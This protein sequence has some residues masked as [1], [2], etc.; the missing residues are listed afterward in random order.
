[1]VDGRSVRRRWF[2]GDGPDK[3][4]GAEGERTAFRSDSAVRQAPRGS[5]VEG[6]K[7]EKVPVAELPGWFVAEVV[8]AEL[9]VD[10]AVAGGEFEEMRVGVIHERPAV[11]LLA[12]IDKDQCSKSGRDEEV[13][14][15][16]AHGGIVHGR[17]PE[18]KGIRHTA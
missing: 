5:V 8:G 3:A 6:G 17:L 18:A 4:E 10:G 2:E 16:V 9:L 7:K 13:R 12:G 14:E 11:L 1:M 15:L